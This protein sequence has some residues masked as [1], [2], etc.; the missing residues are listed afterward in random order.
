VGTIVFDNDTNDLLGDLAT[1]G[2]SLIAAAGGR[3]GRGNMRFAT[4]TNRTPRQA[5]PGT[6]GQERTLRLE[7]KLLADVG[8]L[9]LPNVGKSTL[10]SRLSAAR[11]KVADYPFTTLVPNLGVVRLG[12]DRSFVM[13]DIPGIIRG[14]SEGAGLGLRFLRHVQRSAVLL[15]I[16]ALPADLEDTLLRDF[17]DLSAELV[18]FDEQLAAR[19]RLVALNKADLS[20]TLAAEPALREALSERGF[21]LVVL[22][23]ATGQGLGALRDALGRM[24][25]ERGQPLHEPMQPEDENPGSCEQDRTD[26]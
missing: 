10:I 3:G 26:Q 17:D 21:E 25:V 11:P 5:E 4:P 15:H 22:S 14:A 19:P 24:L 8:L 6:A 1:P 9:G 2:Q 7:L 12:D 16:V 20:E 23:A 13:A 18:R